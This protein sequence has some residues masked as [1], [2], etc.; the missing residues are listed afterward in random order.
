MMRIF[1]GLELPPQARLKI[2]SWRDRSFKELTATGRARPVPPENFHITLAFIGEIT[3]RKLEHLCDSVDDWLEERPVEAAGVDVNQLGYWRRP[4][5]LWIG[6]KQCPGVLLQ[7]A[8]GLKGLGIQAGGKRDDKAFQPH[9][10]L[11]RHCRSA[12]PTPA[13]PP[14]F[15]LCYKSFAL[16]ESRPAKQGVSYHALRHWQLDSRA[17][18]ERRE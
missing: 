8:N 3:E 12:P 7:L 14:E 10:T 17:Q 4:G 18:W 15:S 1:F 13:D 11:F 2:A 9:I 16:F 5:I 6:P